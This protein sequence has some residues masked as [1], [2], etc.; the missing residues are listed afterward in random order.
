MERP[1]KTQYELFL[2]VDRER[3][4]LGLS[5]RKFAPLI[6]IHFTMYSK[7]QRGDRKLGRGAMEKIQA[8]WPGLISDELMEEANW[9]GFENQP[10][11]NSSTD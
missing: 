7:W 6:G 10:N 2:Y 1:A 11:T 9:P 5:V 4:R 8:K 3:T